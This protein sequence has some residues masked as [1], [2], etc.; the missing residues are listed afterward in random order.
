MLELLGRCVQ[1]G[2]RA[3]PG[4]NI[5]STDIAALALLRWFLFGIWMSKV[6]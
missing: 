5:F 4:L 6:L 2:I 3:K 1:V